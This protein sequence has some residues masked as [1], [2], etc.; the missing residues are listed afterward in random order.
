M[1][2][3]LDSVTLGAIIGAISPVITFFI[4]LKFIYPFEFSDKSLH[5]IWI[6]TMSP[7][8]LSLA[9]I[10]N[11]A[12]FLIFAYTN[13]LQTARGILGATIILAILVFIL[14]FI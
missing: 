14:K 1:K 7:K 11:L 9:A 10:P 6:H 3:K 8:I 5:T 2:K 13:R 12:T 4:V